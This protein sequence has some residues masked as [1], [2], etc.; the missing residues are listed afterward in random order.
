MPYTFWAYIAKK[1][2]INIISVLLVLVLIIYVADFLEILRRTFNSQTPIFI[3]LKIVAL[4]I[5]YF[6]QVLIPFVILISTSITFAE[7]NRNLEI[8]AAKSAGLSIWNIMVPFISVAFT[9]G[10]IIT[11]LLNPIVAI[12]L[13]KNISLDKAIIQNN[14]KNDIILSDDGIWLKEMHNNNLSQII[15]AKSLYNR[16]A[17]FT[18]VMVV[19]FN[20]GKDFSIKDTYF[21]DVASISN[22]VITLNKVTHLTNDAR[23]NYSDN[24]QL[25]TNISIKYLQK[26][27]E[28]P[29]ILSF[30]EIKKFIQYLEKGGFSTIPHQIYY[31]H[32]LLLP[33]FLASI[34]L[35]SIACSTVF[36]RSGNISLM[37]TLSIFLGFIVY[38]FSK[39]LYALGSSGSISP[40][41][42]TIAPSLLCSLSSLIYLLHKEDG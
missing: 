29:E 34:T 2:T 3:I 31:Y 39:T 14:A 33:V 41:I 25:K 42:A 11:F 12:T 10:I 9:I 1:Y 30:F 18:D 17:Y 20:K 23:V 13:K 15:N 36:P 22:H 16:G 37:L 6:L 32:L 24:I 40:L 38:L 28:I 35:M 19:I 26:T 27:I 7:L 4:K 5:P 21:A 8:I